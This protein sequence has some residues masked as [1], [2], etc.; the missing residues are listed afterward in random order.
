[1]LS[2]LQHRTPVRTYTG[3]TCAECMLCELFHHSVVC[4]CVRTQVLLCSKDPPILCSKNL[5]PPTSGF[6]LQPDVGFGSCYC[7]GSSVPCWL[8]CTNEFTT[9]PTSCLSV[10]SSV[11]L[12]AS[13][14]ET[15]FE[16]GLAR[17]RWGSISQQSA[18]KASGQWISSA[19]PRFI[20]MYVCKY[21]CIHPSIYLFIFRDFLQTL[22]S[23]T[24]NIVRALDSV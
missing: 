16:S 22:L 21:V 12:K 9:S 8:H 17:A 7:Y 1:M 18:A 23:E 10:S 24:H 4:V 14:L 11:L 5:H 13:Q 6:C 2:K 15:Q 19:F 20:S 3:C